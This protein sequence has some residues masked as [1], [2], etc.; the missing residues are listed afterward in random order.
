ME[1]LKSNHHMSQSDL[2]RDFNIPQAMQTF[3]KAKVEPVDT[4]GVV[5]ESEGLQGEVS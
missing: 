5:S 1:S 3:L 4:A 2:Y